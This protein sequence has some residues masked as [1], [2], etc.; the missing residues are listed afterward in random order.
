MNM[1][2]VCLLFVRKRS[3]MPGLDLG[4]I[5]PGAHNSHK[6]LSKSSRNRFDLTCSQVI[7]CLAVSL[8]I[9][10]DRTQMST[11]M[12]MSARKG[13]DDDSQRPRWRRYARRALFVIEVI[14]VIGFLVV[15]SR[16]W[17]MQNDLQRELAM[18]E[19]VQ[20]ALTDAQ[21]AKGGNDTELKE[22]KVKEITATHPPLVRIVGEIRV[23][24]PALNHATLVAGGEMWDPS[25]EKVEPK[26][27]STVPGEHGDLVLESVGDDGAQ[28]VPDLHRLR[29]GNEVLVVSQRNTFR[30]QIREVTVLAA[31]EAWELIQ[32]QNADLSLIT[33]ARGDVAAQRFVVLAY[34]E[35]IETQ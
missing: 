18:A 31:D 5:A 13:S 20:A 28:A 35:D 32:R 33:S 34:L 8:Q 21:S 2:S 26:V 7:L 14:A 4:T 29:V 1:S 10:G 19:K 9:G 27:L 17:R 30:Y 24:I 15:G 11:S 22:P 6:I 3:S 12:P 25:R 23:V 16:L